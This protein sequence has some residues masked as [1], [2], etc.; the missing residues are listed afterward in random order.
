[1][2]EGVGVEQTHAEVCRRRDHSPI[3]RELDHP[4][5]VERSLTEEV[6]GGDLPEAQNAFRVAGRHRPTVGPEPGLQLASYPFVV[7]R[8][9]HNRRS[10]G[11]IPYHEFGLPRPL[12]GLE[13]GKVPAVRTDGY[14]T[15][16]VVMLERRADLFPRSPVPKLDESVRPEIAGGEGVPVGTEG[17]G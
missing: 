9:P 11:D 10:R 5:A 7:A 14:L 15:D 8:H 16:D 1:R 12:P 6:A 17:D 13:G 4:A 3:G 2:G